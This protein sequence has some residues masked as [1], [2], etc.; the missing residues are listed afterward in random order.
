MKIAAVEKEV[1]KRT[2]LGPLRSYGNKNQVY[3]KAHAVVT[4]SE[5]DAQMIREL[6]APMGIA[7]LHTVRFTASPW[8]TLED[9]HPQRRFQDRS[10]LVFVGN[11]R[12]PT[13]VQGARILS[14]C[15]DS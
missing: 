4:I 14:M 6:T 13:N 12:N 10:G 1:R 11:G 7:Q 5:A 15:E 9:M 3:T 2:Y 8:E